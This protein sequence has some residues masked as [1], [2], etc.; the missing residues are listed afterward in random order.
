MSA[1]HPI[2]LQVR[3]A[4]KVY[5]GTRALKGVDFD[6]RMGAVNVLVG[7]NG[8]GKSTLMKVIAGVE[9]LTEGRILVGGEEKQFRSKD[10]AVTAGVGI[11][12]QELNLFPEMTVAENVFM[13]RE[14]TRFG[15]DVKDNEVLERTRALMARLE[16]KI[17]PETTLG[18]LR[19]GQQQI[20]EIAKALAQDTNIL[21]LDEPTS[22]LSAQEV[23][24]LFRIIED[25]KAQGVG[26]VYISHRL[27]ELIRIGDYITVL[28]DGE[29]TG[30]R[31]MEGVD[32]PWIVRAMIGDKSKDFA[33][34][35]THDYGPT[36]FEARDVSLAR[37][38]GGWTVDHVSMSVRA[39]EVLGVYGLMG[40]GRSEFLECVMGQ[41]PTARGTIEVD[42]RPLD[43]CTVG[44]RIQRG[45]AI[46]PEDRKRDGLVQVMAIRE[47][48]T[49]SSLP[50]LARWFDLSPAIEASKAS[51]FIK[52][53]TIKVASAENPVSSLSG[54]NQQK[55]VIGKALMTEPKVLL[56]DEPSRGIDIGAKAEIYRT[57]RKLAAEGLAIVFVT[58]DIEEVLA[59]SDRILVMADG[60]VTR[61]FPHGAPASDVVTAA[62]PAKAGA[63]PVSK[64]DN[65][66]W[67]MQ[68]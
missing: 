23:N 16:Q 57:I 68:P 14:P 37:A 59:L 29:I 33:S 11:V 3:N 58:S 67:P 7:E 61:E 38:G 47:N 19:I 36:M 25:L 10:D 2:G 51:E 64:K 27:E 1:D 21:I 15:V 8:A 55:V 63:I 20:V 52:R 41:H 13:G 30:A 22:A 53:L 35:I 39:G 6:I 45:I 44:Q 54:G 31:S 18:H 4:V 34:E 46:V 9:D 28:R 56:M 65:A 60:R 50:R 26:I 32:I 42:G 17:A 49:L 43:G 62:N 40:A 5:P 24:V 66:E 12:F 48:L